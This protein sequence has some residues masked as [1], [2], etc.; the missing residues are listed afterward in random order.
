[1][2][3]LVTSVILLLVV[4]GCA[5]REDPKPAVQITVQPALALVKYNKMGVRKEPLDN[6]DPKNYVTTVNHG[7]KVTVLQ[8]DTL[9]TQV[10][11]SDDKTTGWIKTAY[12]VP[13]DVKYA[14]MLINELLVYK[15]PDPSSGS[16]K[17]D[18]TMTKQGIILW[19]T[20]EKDGYDECLFPNGRSGWIAS[21]ELIF[22]QPEID[23][24][25]L[26][27]QARVLVAE[28]KME[29]AATFYQK[30]ANQYGS[31]KIAAV[32]AEES[33]IKTKSE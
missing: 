21:G 3:H 16:I 15:R 25:K 11:L 32:V 13:A 24:A 6:K 1:M 22:D 23:A 26:L 33:G 28:G 12:L 8:Q 17:T 2:K 14:V 30:I 9:W 5:K 7:E 10:K 20:K 19:V 31:S 27:E 4:F 29:E 18:S